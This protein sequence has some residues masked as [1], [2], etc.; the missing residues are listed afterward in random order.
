MRKPPK[1]HIIL[2]RNKYVTD[3]LTPKTTK[4][5]NFQPQK[6]VRP[7]VIYTE[8][9]PHGRRCRESKSHLDSERKQI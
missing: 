8:S 5:V 3:L 6:Y 7:L 4:S 9:T 1:T 2:R